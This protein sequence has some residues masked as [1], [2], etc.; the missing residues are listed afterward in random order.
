MQLSPFDL[1]LGYIFDPIPTLEGIRI[2]EG[3][4]CTLLYTLGTTS[5]AAFGMVAFIGGAQAPFFGVIPLLAV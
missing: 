3:S 1:Y 4:L 2:Q 5:V